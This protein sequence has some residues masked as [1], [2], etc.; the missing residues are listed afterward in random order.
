MSAHHHVLFSVLSVHIRVGICSAAS[1]SSRLS[2]A[3]ETCESRIACGK[4]E[5]ENPPVPT[6][7]IGNLKVVGPDPERSGS[8][9]QRSD[10][11]HEM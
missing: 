7:N 5:R 4:I 10:D 6:V 2:P 9:G 11:V 8:G 1:L 3:Y